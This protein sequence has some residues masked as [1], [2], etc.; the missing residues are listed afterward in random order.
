MRLRADK[1]NKLVAALLAI[2]LGSL[3]LHRFYLG[4]VRQGVLYIFCLVGLGAVGL[5]VLVPV[6]AFIEGI[7]LLTMSEQRFDAIYNSLGTVQKSKSRQRLQLSVGILLTVFIL[8][9]IWLMFAMG[10]FTDFKELF[11]GQNTSQNAPDAAIVTRDT[12]T[13]DERKPGTKASTKSIAIGGT[14]ILRLCG[15]GTGKQVSAGE[16][17]PTTL[18]FRDIDIDRAFSLEFIAGNGKTCGKEISLQV[19]KTAGFQKVSFFNGVDRWTY[20]L[21]QRRWVAN[22]R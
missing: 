14:D 19:L 4:Q 18:N 15:R 20:D 3:G 17:D 21:N 2:F 16:I 8:G 11:F 13:S 9:L 12:S 7:V 6:V 5:W 10:V 1:K 22:N